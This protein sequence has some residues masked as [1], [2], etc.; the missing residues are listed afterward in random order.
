MAHSRGVPYCAFL[1]ETWKRVSARDA[2]A[3]KCFRR[4]PRSG[5][6]TDWVVNV[7]AQG[8]ENNLGGR[9]W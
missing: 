4:D 6:A 2:L 1:G 7:E 9:F 3:L 8:A 5:L